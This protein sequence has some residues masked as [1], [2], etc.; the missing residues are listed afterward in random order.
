[1]DIL[2]SWRDTI[3]SVLGAGTAEQVIKKSD[4]TDF[5]FEFSNSVL[6]ASG[7][8]NLKVK[9]VQI[10]DWNMDTS[11]S[12]S[13]A[14]GISDSSKIRDLRVMIRHDSSSTLYPL[15]YTIDNTN[16]TPQGGLGNISTTH[17]TLNRLDGG[18]FD[19][20][21]FNSTGFN[22]GFITIIYEG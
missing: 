14:H 11:G 21:S 1:M 17:I 4:N 13:V 10:G 9:V 3:N 18:V 12:V 7:T 6:P 15:T 5:N 20:S 16:T 8:G 2:N 19:G 22:R